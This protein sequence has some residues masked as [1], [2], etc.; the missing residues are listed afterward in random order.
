MI[1]S[2]H[3]TTT[4]NVLL[5]IAGVLTIV[6]LAPFLN[7]YLPPMVIGE[8]NIDL[9]VSILLAFIA[10]RLL[11]I[12]FKPLIIPVLVL[13]IGFFIYNLI[14]NGYTFGDVVTDYRSV[15]LNNWGTKD[16]KDSRRHEARTA[17]ATEAHAWPQ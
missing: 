17:A 5:E 2:K 16:S 14:Y 12:L 6:P 15:V 9:I 3:Y 13:T 8:W 4:Q 1:T 11:L 10:V 7:R